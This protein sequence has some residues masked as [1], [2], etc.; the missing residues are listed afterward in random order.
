MLMCAGV[1]VCAMNPAI[2]EKI[3]SFFDDSAKNNSAQAANTENN[4]NQGNNTNPGYNIIP[5]N[6]TGSGNQGNNAGGSSN[7]NSQ[8]PS[9]GNALN[10]TVVSP[11]QSGNKHT[12][13]GQRQKWL[14]ARQGHGTEAGGQ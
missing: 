1:L 12:R 3:A 14:S 13:G 10:N 6:Q 11:Y 4:G 9:G 2:T 5:G 8:V 7:G